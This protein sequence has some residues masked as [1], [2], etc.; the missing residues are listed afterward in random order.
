LDAD[1]SAAVDGAGRKDDA[2][3]DGGFEH[4]DV[5]KVGVFGTVDDQMEAWTAKLVEEGGPVRVVGPA[6]VL[7]SIIRNGRSKLTEPR[8]VP[9]NAAPASIRR[10]WF[11]APITVGPPR[12]WPYAPTRVRSSTA[13]SNVW[14]MPATTY[15][16]LASSSCR[17][18]LMAAGTPK[19]WEKSTIG[20]RAPRKAGA[21]C[22][23]W[24]GKD[25]RSVGRS[26]PV[27]RGVLNRIERASSVI[28]T[29][30]S[31]RLTVACHTS[32]AL[33]R[34]KSLVKDAH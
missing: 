18:V 33:E 22:T 21:S 16:L 27:I 7:V 3:V 20:R 1:G 32:S 10:S 19:P 30:S 31:P 9:S 8:R 17:A 34:S 12:E 13:V 28:C 15:P 2:D 23:P 29:S 24:A 5:G 26:R 6:L 11:M 14:S 25:S 4:G